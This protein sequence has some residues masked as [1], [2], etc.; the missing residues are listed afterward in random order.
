[1]YIYIYIY[2]C[3][4]NIWTDMHGFIS[5]CVFVHQGVAVE[6]WRHLLRVPWE[7]MTLTAAIG[8]CEWQQ[9]LALL[10]DMKRLNIRETW[11]I[12]VSKS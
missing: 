2:L 5:E 11:Q 12:W 8:L 6:K 3:V 9:V 7:V 1:M 10:E 4:I